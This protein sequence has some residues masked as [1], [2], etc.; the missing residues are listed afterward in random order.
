MIVASLDLRLVRLVRAAMQPG[1]GAAGPDRLV[2]PGPTIEP[3]KRH[4][5]EPEIE[6]RKRVTPEPHF[7]PRPVFPVRVASIA[8]SDVCVVV[9]VQKTRETSSGSPI[10]PPWKV[11]PWEMTPEAA[12]IRFARPVQ[13]V[14]VVTGRPDIPC[15][16][17]VIDVFI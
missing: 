3:R 4:E 11:L 10:E 17:S 1:N 8:R 2:R 14:K 7:E 9:E 5:P 6:P 12:P 13:R 16:G 15:S